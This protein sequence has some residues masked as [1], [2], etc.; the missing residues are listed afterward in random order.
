MG[1][2]DASSQ[3]QGLMYFIS[4]VSQYLGQ[5]MD[6]NKISLMAEVHLSESYCAQGQ[7]SHPERQIYWTCQPSRSFS[8]TTNPML[9]CLQ[10]HTIYCSNYL[11][12]NSFKSLVLPRLRSMSLGEERVPLLSSA[13]V[14]SIKHRARASARG[15]SV[16]I[17]PAKSW[18]QGWAL[19]TTIELTAPWLPPP[20]L[21]LSPRPG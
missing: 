9:A 13:P 16:S 14:P 7:S 2:H 11:P 8:F 3:G 5:C 6:A 1:P 12:D 17:C 18:L 21:I 4:M 19:F 20:S 15:C 10:G